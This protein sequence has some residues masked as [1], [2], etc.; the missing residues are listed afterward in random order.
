[1]PIYIYIIHLENV[2]SIIH[3]GCTYFICHPFG[4]VHIS[5]IHSGR[6]RHIMSSIRG[7][8]YILC[9]PLGEAHTYYVIHS[10]TS[11]HN[12][13]SIRG[14]TYICHLFGDV[15]NIYYVINSGMYMSSI[16]GNDVIH[17]RIY[18]YHQR[19]GKTNLFRMR[20]GRFH[21]GNTLCT[22]K[23]VRLLLLKIYVLFTE[24][25]FGNTD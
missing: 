8:T 17:S 18:I 3:S 1:M 23:R 6:Y 21:A 11:I 13:S 19:A 25:I 10:G 15:Y 24:H 2:R 14:R 20:G 7:G 16:R 12:M 5:V 4:E 9:R 22:F